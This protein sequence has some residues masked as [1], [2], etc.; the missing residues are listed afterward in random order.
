[1]TTSELEAILQ[2][3]FES[4]IAK[5]FLVSK[6]NIELER[7]RDS[8]FNLDLET[9]QTHRSNFISDVSFEENGNKNSVLYLS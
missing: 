1:M 7:S 3:F 2:F 9:I 4:F 6:F 8:A 5:G